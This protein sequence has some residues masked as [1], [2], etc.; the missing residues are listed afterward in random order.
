MQTLQSGNFIKGG[1]RNRFFGGFDQVFGAYPDGAKSPGAFI[2]PMRPGALASRTSNSFAFS[3]NATAFLAKPLAGSTSFAFSLPS[4][5]LQLRA[6]L[7]GSSSFS[8][9]ASTASLRSVI[10]L[11]AAPSFSFSTTATI[12][13][14]V[15]LAASTSFSFSATSGI[16]RLLFI[17]GS[18]D[19]GALTAENIAE[20]VWTTDPSSF[21]SGTTGKKLNEV[22]TQTKFL[23]LK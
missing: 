5:E 18:T 3:S 20:A 11:Q 13:K 15:N 9:S 7:S 6:F 8:F 1:L 22:L 17:E 12:S 4:A 16:R 14:I 23:A 19:S 21:G 2:L 10:S